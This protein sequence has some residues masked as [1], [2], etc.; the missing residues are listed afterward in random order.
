MSDEN[1]QTV[2]SSAEQNG[3]PAAAGAV[4]QEDATVTA[5]AVE[6]GAADPIAQL[7]ALAAERDQLAAENA[8]VRDRLLRR[9]ADFENLRKRVEREKAEIREYAGMEVLRALLEILDSFE[10]AVKVECA[11]KDY[12]KGMELIQQRLLETLGKLGLEPIASEGQKFDPYV[13]H[14]VETVETT[15]TD[16][17]TILA[18]LQK[19]YNFRGRLL[20]PAMVKVAVAPSS[21]K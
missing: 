21:G 17:H 11:D 15:D 13:H 18:E 4:N 19:G 2:A 8:L 5:E 3:E 12:A 10:R 1:V 9:Q 7:A 6:A 20:R 14:A 16:D